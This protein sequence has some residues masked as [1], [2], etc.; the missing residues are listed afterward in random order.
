MPELQALWSRWNLALY[1]NRLLYIFLNTYILLSEFPTQ[2]AEPVQSTACD[3][4]MLD[5]GMI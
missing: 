3:V 1:K 5:S 2:A 4:I